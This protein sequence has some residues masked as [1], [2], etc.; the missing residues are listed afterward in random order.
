[1]AHDPEREGRSRLFVYGTLKRGHTAADLLR[2]FGATFVGNARVRGQL[3]DLG[4][5]PGLVPASG[6]GSWV[7]GELYDLPGPSTS[8]ESLDAYEGCGPADPA[9]HEFERRTCLVV[10]EDGVRRNA[11]AYFYLG[12]VAGACVIASGAWDV[13]PP[14]GRPVCPGRR[15]VVDLP[16]HP[17][18]ERGE[19]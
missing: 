2:S 14:A 9:P 12:G 8:F 16:R 17:I 4:T 15:E 6:E 11:W 3:V 10:C 18:Q 5:Y 19:T 7:E 1:M 13:Q